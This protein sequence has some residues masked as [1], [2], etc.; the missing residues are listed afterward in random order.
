[1]DHVFYVFV[2]VHGF[3]YYPLLNST[4]WL[5]EL[6]LDPK[7]KYLN[8]YIW[9]PKNSAHIYYDYL[10]ILWQKG[11]VFGSLVTVGPSLSGPSMFSPAISELSQI[12]MQMH[13]VQRLD[14]T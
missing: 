14:S 1:M 6:Q 9:L 3:C 11:T 12:Q 8:S 2:V 5:L 7:L 4:D 10:L 13:T